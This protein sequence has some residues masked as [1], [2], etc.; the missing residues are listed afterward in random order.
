MRGGRQCTGSKTSLT[1]A[2][3]ITLD[4]KIWCPP[5]AQTCRFAFV[6]PRAL[7]RAVHPQG[8]VAGERPPGCCFLAGRF[9][10]EKLPG[11]DASYQQ[12]VSVANYI[13]EKEKS[14]GA[15]PEEE[16]DISMQALV[17]ED[18]GDNSA[19]AILTG[20]QRSP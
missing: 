8:L 2:N 13:E 5:T 12:E 14:G 4:T 3:F 11:I 7:W 20:G 9:T 10:K 15:K 16:V 6:S 17:S 19:K 1:S 18:G